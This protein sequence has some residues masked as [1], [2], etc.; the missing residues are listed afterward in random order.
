MAT[1]PKTKQTQLIKTMLLAR[2]IDFTVQLTTT[3][4]KLYHSLGC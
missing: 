4:E 3:K 2:F 1:Q